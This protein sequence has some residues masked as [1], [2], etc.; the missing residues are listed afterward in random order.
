MHSL[1]TPA[2]AA[3]LAIALSGTPLAHS[4]AAIEFELVARTNQ[5][6]PG[7]P[8]G[9]LL[10]E[11]QNPGINNAG[12]CIFSIFNDTLPNSGLAIV[13]RW[14]QAGGLERIAESG[15][16]V[17]PNALNLAWA[18]DYFRYALLNDS[19]QIVLGGIVEGLGTDISNNEIFVRLTEGVAA[20]IARE[21]SPAPG[22]GGATYRN[23]ATSSL[24]SLDA[25]GVVSFRSQLSGNTHGA[26]RGIP[27]SVGAVALQD[28]P[29]TGNPLLVWE[30]VSSI[31]LGPTNRTLLAGSTRTPAGVPLSGGI[32]FA[33]LDGSALAIQV[34]V[35]QP[36]PDDPTSKFSPFLKP[37]ANAQGVLSFTTNAVDANDVPLP[38]GFRAYAGLPNSLTNVTPA[39]FAAHLGTGDYTVNLVLPTRVT[40]DGRLA[41]S[42]QIDFAT[43]RQ[44]A[45]ILRQAN[46][47]FVTVATTGQ[48]VT[49]GGSPVTISGASIYPEGINDSGDMLVT[50]FGS[51]NV[52]YLAIAREVPDPIIDATAPS[53]DIRGRRKIVTQRKRFRVRGTAA[54]ETAL[55]RVEFKLRKQPFRTARGTDRWKQR[56]RL[57]PG[58]N[59]ILVRVIDSA[60]NISASAKQILVR[61]PRS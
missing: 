48:T 1:N 50:L 31:G 45:V 24:P 6:I 2:R 30:F 5:P 22:T 37:N 38:G 49:L 39:G 27:G 44:S 42:A 7:D 34:A 54:D 18:P 8:N 52:E 19:G 43:G 59:R 51:D 57:R 40:P 28:H 26:W 35:G 9:S 53:I 56:V 4:T 15:G 13:F 20:L 41:L 61:R 21:G 58:R 33:N 47:Q 14:T 29:V 23:L 46:G 3:F 10:E 25:S 32:Y 12:D 17:L 36:L 16:P 60:G 55:D 11:I